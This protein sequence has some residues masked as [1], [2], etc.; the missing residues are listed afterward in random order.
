[1]AEVSQV[2][3]RLDFVFR[4]WFE[5]LQPFR[6]SGY[7]KKWPLPSGEGLDARFCPKYDSVL[8]EK[9]NLC[10][11]TEPI[12]GGGERPLRIALTSE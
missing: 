7:I 1:M 2:F 6:V 9:T 3:G 11:S 5:R 4:P 12:E 10:R 8:L